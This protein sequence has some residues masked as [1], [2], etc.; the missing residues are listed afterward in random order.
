MSLDENNF[1]PDGFTDD[2]HMGEEQYGAPV[3]GTE[4]EPW[5]SSLEEGAGRSYNVV[6]DMGAAPYTAE[7]PTVD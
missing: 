3:Y 7:I 4:P 2:G 5:N 1:V 6:P